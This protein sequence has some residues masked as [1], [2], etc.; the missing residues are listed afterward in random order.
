VSLPKPKPVAKHESSQRHEHLESY[1]NQ[2]SDAVPNPRQGVLR[3]ARRQVKL[4]RQ[5][6]TVKEIVL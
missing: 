3:D 5:Q 2:S 4:I 6:R 1:W